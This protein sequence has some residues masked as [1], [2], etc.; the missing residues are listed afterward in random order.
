MTL[1]P[2]IQ[3]RAQ[4]EIDLVVGAS[5]LP[6]FADR[7]S[8]SYIDALVKEVYRWHPVV[9][10]GFPHVAS[11]DDIYEGMFI[12]KGAILIPNIW[13]FAHDECNYKDP[14]IFNPER[15]L[16]E[17]PE[18]DPNSLIFGFGKRICP[19]KDF[20]DESVFLTIAM[21][22]AVFDIRKAKDKRG[23]AIEPI[24]SF[25]PGILSRPLAFSCDISP[26]S[27]EAARLIREVEIDFPWENSDVEQLDR[28]KWQ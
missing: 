27:N 1:H 18:M 24:S 17:T 16:G 5:R 19:G 22:L 12:P 15:F 20:A 2:E 26:R 13:L 9:P 7:P 21:T 3:K 8:L 4:E 23:D 6:S 11:S 28:V 14:Q 25:Q 10:M